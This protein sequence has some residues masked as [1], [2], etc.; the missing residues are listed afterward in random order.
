[1]YLRSVF[2]FKNNHEY[3]CWLAQ[4][5]SKKISKFSFL[6]RHCISDCVHCKRPSLLL[7][8]FYWA[9]AAPALQCVYRCSRPSCSLCKIRRRLYFSWVK[10]TEIGYRCIHVTFF[11]GL[12]TKRAL[13]FQLWKRQNK[14]DLKHKC[15]HISL[16][17]CHNRLVKHQVEV[18]T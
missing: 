6:L 11:S 5:L 4:G 8:T 3:Y 17:F 10:V 14:K 12:G 16:V 1:M 18:I 2:S 15:V 13:T 9:V 7:F